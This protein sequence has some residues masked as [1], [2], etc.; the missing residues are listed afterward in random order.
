MSPDVDLEV[1][2][3]GR[4]E[5]YTGADLKGVCREAAMEALR[6]SMGVGVVVGLCSSGIPCSMPILIDLMNF[7][8][9]QEGRHFDAALKAV[10][11]T[12]S[13]EMLMQY[14]DFEKRFGSGTKG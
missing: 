12:L 7:F 4:T 1:I 9:M 14:K 13:S 10:T 6:E 2:S 5:R 3:G 8:V 11:P